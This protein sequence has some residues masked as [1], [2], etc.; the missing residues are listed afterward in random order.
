MRIIYNLLLMADEVDITDNVLALMRPHRDSGSMQR[1]TSAQPRISRHAIDRY[2]QRVDAVTALEAAQ[3]LTLLAS[4][5]TRRPTPRHWMD[6]APAPGTLFLYPTEDSD[7]C[8]VLKGD[9]IVTVFSRVICMS[10]RAPTD[11]SQ[12]ARIR[13]PYRRPAPGSW[14]LEVA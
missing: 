6:V 11:T 12:R 10:W 13:R 7:I 4:R 9:T 14:P 5:A 3:R 1:Q 2:I 8:L